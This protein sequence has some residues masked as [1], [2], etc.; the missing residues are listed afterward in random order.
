[1]VQNEARSFT[2]GCNKFGASKPTYCWVV[3]VAIQQIE[4]IYRVQSSLT[5]L[6]GKRKLKPINLDEK[7][8]KY[9]FDMKYKRLICAIITCGLTL[10][11]LV[12]GNHNVNI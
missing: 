12:D 4:K 1:M 11:T 10:P 5:R 2:R 9:T 7:K 8:A 3:P 6:A